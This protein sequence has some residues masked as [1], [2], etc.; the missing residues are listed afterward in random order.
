MLGGDVQT[1]RAP[2]PALPDDVPGWR[3]CGS[4]HGYLRSLEETAAA[5]GEIDAVPARRA[6]SGHGQSAPG[7]MIC[8]K[9]ARGSASICLGVGGLFDFWAATSAAR[10]PGCGGWGTDGFGALFQQPRDKAKRYLIGNPPLFLARI[11]GE[12]LAPPKADS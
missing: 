3:L 4:H 2:P 8:Q 11:F 6:I 10:Q 12:F 9:I 7:K 1:A 5:I